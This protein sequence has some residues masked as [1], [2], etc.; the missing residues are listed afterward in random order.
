MKKL[1]LAVMFAAVTVLSICVY[2][3]LLGNEFFKGKFTNDAISWYFLAK[4]LFCSIA[5]YLLVLILEQLHEKK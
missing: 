2:T 1:K 4:G 5:L 3:F